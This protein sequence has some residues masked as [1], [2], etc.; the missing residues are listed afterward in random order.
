MRSEFEN[1][2]V[3]LKERMKQQIQENM[4]VERTKLSQ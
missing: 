4:N 2:E 3:K 1:R